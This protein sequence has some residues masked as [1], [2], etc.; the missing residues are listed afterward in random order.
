[1]QRLQFPCYPGTWTPKWRVSIRWSHRR[2]AG[3][4]LL[5]SSFHL[6]YGLRFCTILTSPN[7]LPRFLPLSISHV[8]K[9]RSNSRI[10]GKLSSYIFSLSLYS[11]FGKIDFLNRND[12]GQSKRNLFFLLFAFFIM[13]MIIIKHA[14]IFYIIERIRTKRIL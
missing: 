8:C 1:M 6:R 13:L 12:F 11:D 3:G 7:L 4:L 14:K 2:I 9:L 10:P 5:Y